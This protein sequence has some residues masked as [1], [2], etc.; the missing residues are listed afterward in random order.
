MLAVSVLMSQEG[1]V[2][3][4]GFTSW[5][6]RYYLGLRDMACRTL[7]NPQRPATHVSAFPGTLTPKAC[8]WEQQDTVCQYVPHAGYAG[9]HLGV[10][11]CFLA[12][13]STLTYRRLITGRRAP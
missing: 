3:L 12:A 4:G 2:G 1:I 5:T 10:S 8:V 7:G 6:A 13:A 9:V 11:P